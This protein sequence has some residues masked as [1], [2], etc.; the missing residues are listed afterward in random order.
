MPFTN[1]WIDTGTVW[2]ACSKTIKNRLVRMPITIGYSVFKMWGIISIS[3]N[4]SIT[5]RILVVSHRSASTIIKRLEL[6]VKNKFLKTIGKRFIIVHAGI[7]KNWA[8]LFICVEIIKF[9]FLHLTDF[10]VYAKTTP[11]FCICAVLA[12]ASFGRLM[13]ILALL[14]PTNRS[15]QRPITCPSLLRLFSSFSLC[16]TTILHWFLAAHRSI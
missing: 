9:K 10:S 13:A 5:N 7:I 11:R 14:R 8:S 16:K 6:T 12:A 15:I 3:W 4:H 2:W 1:T